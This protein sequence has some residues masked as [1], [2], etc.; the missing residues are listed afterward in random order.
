MVAALFVLP[1]GPYASLTDVDCWPESRDARLYAGPHPVVAHPPCERWGRYW[2]GGTNMKAPRRKLGDDA[3]CFASALASVRRWGGVLEHPEASHAWGMH[4][5]PAPPRWGGWIQDITGGWTCCVEQGH[6]GHSSRK[7]TWLY[8]VGGETPTDMRW[9][10][11]PVAHPLTIPDRCDCGHALAAHGAEVHPDGSEASDCD[12][13]SCA[14][15]VLDRA[16]RRRMQKRGTLARLSRRKRKLTPD[17]FAA[18]L[19][20]L[21]RQSRSVA[22]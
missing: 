4:G 7:A 17:A 1:D 14:A 19:V 8:L 16:H 20:G 2:N 18:V 3:G 13:C 5:L 21:A 12:E 15:F 9:G 6:Y 22:A 11:A 10:P